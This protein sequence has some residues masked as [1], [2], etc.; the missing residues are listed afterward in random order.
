MDASVYHLDNF[1]PVPFTMLRS[2][3]SKVD[4]TA[5]PRNKRTIF[6][7][8]AWCNRSGGVLHW[9][10]PDVFIQRRHSQARNQANVRIS[11]HNSIR[12]V[13]G[14]ILSRTITCDAFKDSSSC[15][16][17]LHIKLSH[18]RHR[19]IRDICFPVLRFSYCCDFPHAR[20][21]CVSP[22]S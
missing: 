17:V 7:Q 11:K 8:T 6:G 18:V 3:R 20:L 2:S 16:G 22:S 14:R 13:Y 21:P 19:C 4:C 5:R 9:S 12:F 1:P 15:H 10:T